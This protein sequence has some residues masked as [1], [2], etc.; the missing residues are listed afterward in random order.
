MRKPWDIPAGSQGCSGV[1]KGYARKR[2]GRGQGGKL[3]LAGITLCNAALSLALAVL[4]RQEVL[5]AVKGK[6]GEEVRLLLTSR[7]ETKS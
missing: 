7:K 2:G 4:R 6:D 3:L 1:G 5:H